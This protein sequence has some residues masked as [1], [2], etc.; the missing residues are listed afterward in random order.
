M[1]FREHV[2][3]KRRW[4]GYFGIFRC[5]VLNGAL[6]CFVF[7]DR[8]QYVLAVDLNTDTILFKRSVDDLQLTHG[9]DVVPVIGTVPSSVLTGRI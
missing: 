7:K 5:K 6:I 1:A 2:E 9:T 8:K 3:V 4:L